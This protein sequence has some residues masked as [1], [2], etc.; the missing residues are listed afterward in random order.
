MRDLSNPGAIGGCKAR[1]QR[2]VGLPNWAGAMDLNG[3][4]RQG[5]LEPVAIAEF[6]INC[7]HL[8]LRKVQFALSLTPDPTVNAAQLP[9]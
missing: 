6:M 2:C 9:H 4:G 8:P 7:F 1:R 3:L 5:E